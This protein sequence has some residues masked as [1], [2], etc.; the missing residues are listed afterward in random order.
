[1]DLITKAQ[2]GDNDAAAELLEMHN[3]Y[4]HKLAIKW[5]QRFCYRYELEDCLQEGRLGFLDAIRRFD[6]HAGVNLI[7]Y[8]HWYILK[9]LSEMIRYSDVVKVPNRRMRKATLSLDFKAGDGVKELDLIE[10]R[11]MGYRREVEMMDA[12]DFV[13]RLLKVIPTRTRDVLIARMQDR[14]H[15]SIK[16]DYGISRERVRQIEASGYEKIRAHAAENG[17]EML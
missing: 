6:V 5:K 13:D 9:H 7:T 12:A 17:V 1:M 3:G 4:I 11:D 8:G 2:G 14:T 16:G 15:E 10:G